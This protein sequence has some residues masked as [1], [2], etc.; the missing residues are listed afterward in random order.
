M[1]LLAFYLIHSHVYV[2]A[3]QVS[4]WSETEVGPSC[5]IP[6]VYGS[7]LLILPS[8]SREMNS[9]ELGNSFLVQFSVDCWDETM[10][11]RCSGSSFLLHVV[12][13]RCFAPLCC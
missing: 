4:G 1:V 9:A 11:V 12:V 3:L 8:L 6:K 5:T 2:L 13:L 7:Y 10:Q